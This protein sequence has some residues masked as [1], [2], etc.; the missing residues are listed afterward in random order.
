MTG[1]SSPQQAQEPLSFGRSSWSELH[2]QVLGKRSSFVRLREWNGDLFFEFVL[3]RF[4]LR[5][6]VWLVSKKRQ[7]R[8]VG[9]AAFASLPV[10]ES[11]ELLEF[12]LETFVVTGEALFMASCLMVQSFVLN[13][14]A[15][16]FNVTRQC[17]ACGHAFASR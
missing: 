14:R 2:A 15:A 5:C 16:M 17:F 13:Q 7:L 9:Q 10:D 4:G 12:V 3:G 1:I 6:R 11:L 8:I